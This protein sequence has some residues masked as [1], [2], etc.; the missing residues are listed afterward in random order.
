MRMRILS[1]LCAALP[2]VASGQAA[3]TS[4]PAY[5][6]RGDQVDARYQSHRRS[7]ERF[8]NRLSAVLDREAPDLKSKILPP[9]PV[10]YGYQILPKILNDPQENPQKR[11]KLSPFSWSRTDSVISREADS[12]ALLSARLD[13]VAQ[14]KAGDRHKEYSAIAD[15][16]RTLDN[17]QRFI[18]NLIQYNRFWQGEIARRPI[19]YMHEKEMQEAALARESLLDS[20]SAAGEKLDPMIQRQLDSVTRVLDSALRKNPTESYV[21]AWHPSAYQWIV[22]VPMYTDIN[23]SGFLEQ[24]RNAIEDG[25][26]VQDGMNDFRVKL[27]IRHLTPYQLF[28]PYGVAPPKG[29]HIDIAKHTDRFP[30]DGTILTTG[31][32]LTYLFGRAIILGPYPIARRVLV[33]EFGHLLGFKDAYFRAARG[34]GPDGYRVVEVILPPEDVVAAPESGHARRAHFEQVLHLTK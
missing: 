18:S 15:A 33:H 32:N 31:G 4:R 28:Y 11:I 19:V 3:G 10:P 7:L 21:H 25:W 26:H 12:L 23:D 8:F 22:E 20:T 30:H 9:A 24:V 16:Y 2:A 5:L 1:L 27:D 29:A 17:G 6:R 34:E 14:M 13:K